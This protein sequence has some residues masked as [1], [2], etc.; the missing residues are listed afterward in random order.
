MEETGSVLTERSGTII[1]KTAQFKGEIIG[2]EQLVV[3]GKVEGTIILENQVFVEK[4]GIVQADV[5][6]Q[7]IT[8]SGS[9]SG[10]IVVS[11]KAEIIAGGTVVGD[12]KAPRVVIH[13]GARILGRIEMDVTSAPLRVR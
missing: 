8:V 12:I 11:D 4:G 5:T 2:D 3:E 1:G 10:N 7:G 13:D 9:V 6:S